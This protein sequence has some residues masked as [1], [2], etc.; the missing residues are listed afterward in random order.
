MIPS[1]LGRRWAMDPTEMTVG[2]SRLLLVRGDIT[3]QHVDA[4]VNAANSSL[5]GGGGVDGAIHRAGG[6]AILEDCKR[7]RDAQGPL[8]PGQAVATTAGDLPARNVI[9][10][11]GPVW[12]GG[13]EG[14]ADTL[15]EAYRSS[16]GAAAR[17]GARTVAFPSISTGAYGYPIDLAA[18]VAL[19]TVAQTLRERPGE[20]DE[21]RFVLFDGATLAAYGSALGEVAGTDVGGSSGSASEDLLEVRAFLHFAGSVGENGYLRLAPQ[22]D[23][24]AA[25]VAREVGLDP[26]AIGLVMVN[27]CKV[28]L[29]APLTA[30]DRVAFFPDY[31]PFHRVYGMCVL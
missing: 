7:I 5:M 19:R 8:P 26:C 15:A 21:V 4:I 30:G 17:E 12:R 13:A 1:D 23:A 20:I 11:V 9:H 6:P 10:T 31:V 29:E 24:T 2:A 16:L 28:D 14:E 27:G 22:P 18:R 3:K 25:S